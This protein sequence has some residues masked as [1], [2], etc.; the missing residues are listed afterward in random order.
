MDLEKQ[1]TFD[2]AYEQYLKENYDFQENVCVALDVLERKANEA[3]T[4]ANSA[5]NVANAAT[6]EVRELE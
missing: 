3:A 6:E 2:D 5:R 4:T 1:K